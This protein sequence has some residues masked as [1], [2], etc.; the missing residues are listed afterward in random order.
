MNNF[1]RLAPFIQDFIYSKRWES[2]RDIQVRTCDAVFDTDK[3]ILLAASTASGKTEN[4]GYFRSI[5]WR[6]FI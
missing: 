2:L 1:D 3:N 6:E 4:P 5:I